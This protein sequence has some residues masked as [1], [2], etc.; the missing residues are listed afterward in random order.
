MRANNIIGIIY[1]NAYDYSLSELTS[2]RAMSSVPFCSRYR[3]IDFPLSNFVNCGISKVGI[4]TKSNYQSLMDH[5]GNGKAWDLSRKREGLYIL[6]PF[7]SG[8]SSENRGRLESLIG[9]KDFLAASKEEYVLFSDCNI[10]CNYD[11]KKLFDFHTKK[12]ADITIV[13]KHGTVPKLR[14]VMALEHGEDGKISA[15]TTP[16]END[17]AD[18]STNIILIRKSLLERLI[19]EAVSL[20]F[21][22]FTMGIIQRNVEKLNMYAL[23]CEGFFETVDS[24]QSYFDVSMKL[25]DPKNMK[26]LFDKEHPIYT[27]DR[28]DMP[29]IYG[30]GSSVHNSLIADGCVIDGTVENSIIFRGARIAKG[31]H[32]KNCIIMQNSYISENVKLDCI[33]TDKNVVVKPNNNLAGALTYPVYIG[34]G[35]TI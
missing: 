26:L 17:V 20:H 7:H 12:N 34:K 28:D 3:F 6:P 22:S 33:I 18:Y 19:N 8:V 32:V 31:A 35:I 16:N 13:Y 29:A 15:I 23:E 25:L 27:K 4:V 24:L 5:V 21:Q 2:L 1:S 14:D 10:I 30:L 9:I 11:L